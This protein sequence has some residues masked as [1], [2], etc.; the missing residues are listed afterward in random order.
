MIKF[1][2]PFAVSALINAEF[3]EAFDILQKLEVAG[4]TV[5]FP[6]GGTAFDVIN[7]SNAQVR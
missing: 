1:V 3:D 6:G 7:N 2:I 4:G 5:P